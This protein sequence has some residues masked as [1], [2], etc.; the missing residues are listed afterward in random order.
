MFNA[1]F[2]V[3]MDVIT[4]SDPNQRGCQLSLRFSCLIEDVHQKLYQQG[5]IVSNLCNYFIALFSLCFVVEYKAF[6][7]VLPWC[8]RLVIKYLDI[9]IE[10]SLYIT[11]TAEIS[12][13]L[14]AIS[15]PYWWV[16]GW[17]TLAQKHPLLQ[18]KKIFLLCVHKQMN[19]FSK[20][21][22]EILLKWISDWS[23]K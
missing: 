8:V 17:F 9:L 13:S 16:Y 10:Q 20:K 5:I 22:F 4:P 7:L 23:F 21:S 2:L 12:N 11:W 14:T 18:Y 3:T 1:F 19:K 6:I 15:S